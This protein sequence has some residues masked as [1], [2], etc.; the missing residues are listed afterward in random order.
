M[1]VNV[2]QYPVKFFSVPH[3]L[4]LGVLWSLAVILSY[5]L[6]KK[7]GFTKRVVLFCMIAA[8]ASEIQ[9]ITFFMKDT[10]F[11]FRLPAEQLPFNLCTI[12]IFFISTLALSE[13]PKKRFALISFMFPALI[14]GAFVGMVIPSATF[15]YHGL[16]D[17][18]TYRYFIYHAML[19]FLGLYLYMSKPIQFTIKSYGYSLAIMFLIMIAGIWINAFFGWSPETNFCFL[20]RPPTEGLPVLNMNNGWLRYAFGQI[21]ICIVFFFLCYIPVVIRDFPELAKS[22]TGKR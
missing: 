20:V 21:W 1:S 17:L 16:T 13:N 2:V 18:A 7:Y 3:L 8:I 15:N 5:F 4:I 22:I 9:K 6:S 19:I 11:G 10:G 12:Q 14:S